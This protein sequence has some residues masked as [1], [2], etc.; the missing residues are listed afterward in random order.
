VL[1][2]WT[3]Y[4]SSP[5]ASYIAIMGTSKRQRFQ[6]TTQKLCDHER[7]KSQKVV[8]SCLYISRL[9]LTTLSAVNGKQRL[10]VGEL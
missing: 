9:V 3:V 1:G 10:M 4:C 5:V 8:Y 2:L 6:L 7:R